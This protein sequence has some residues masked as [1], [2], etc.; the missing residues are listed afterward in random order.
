MRYTLQNMLAAPAMNLSTQLAELSM[1]HKKSDLF[2]SN[3]IIIGQDGE[4]LSGSLEALLKRLTPTRDFSPDSGY[5]FTVLVN[6]RTVISPEET[7]QR[8]VQNSMFSMNSDSCNFSKEHRTRLFA[9]ILRLCS[10]WATSIPYDFRSDEMRTRLN[11]LLGMCSVDQN[12][13]LKA[14]EI[15]TNLRNA[16]NK[17]DRYEKAVA[18]LHKTLAESPQIP[19]QHDA[20]VGLAAFCP[21]P[22][23][24][25]QQLTHIELERFSMV[26]VD[27]IVNSLDTCDISQLGRNKSSSNTLNTISFYVEWFN[28]L[29]SF[30]ATEVLRQS[31]RKN[32]VQMLEFL[33][34]VARECCE[35]G[36][37]NSLMA[38]VAGLSL[39]PIARLKRTWNRVDKAKLDILQHQLDPS[40]NF[41]SY[42]ATM[43]AAVWRADSARRP[44]QK[45]VV[46][47][48]VL[49]LKDLYMMFHNSTRTLPNGHINFLAYSQVAEQLHK[50]FL[51]KRAPCTFTKNPQVLQY[52]LVSPVYGE[53]ESQL[54]SFDLEQPENSGERELLKRLRL[55]NK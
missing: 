12:N 48:F 32:R 30:S 29:S 25:A 43:K 52:L 17:L 28:R 14:Q 53:R 49:L 15:Q 8:I 16:L 39:P 20:L 47:F 31:K 33:I 6:I 9:H 18:S 41:L 38:I 19:Q 37:F 4:V 45:I 34:D 23:I 3:D 46:P 7:M 5:I 11:E 13:K 55:A 35:M 54:V 40:G 22:K 10:E 1:D 36:N 24:I 26:G 27:E 50:I 2:H 21:D 42:R 51:W 44:E